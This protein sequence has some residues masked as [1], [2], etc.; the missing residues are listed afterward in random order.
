MVIVAVLY[1]GKVI[2]VY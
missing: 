1:I 2:P